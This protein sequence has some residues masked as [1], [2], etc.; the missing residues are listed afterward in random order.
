MSDVSGSRSKPT[1]RSSIR[2]SLNF[3]SVGKAFAD[4]MNKER[5]DSA[6]KTGKD[7]NKPGG[8]KPRA[9]LD[10]KPSPPPS[11]RPRTP[12]SK[13]I[14]ARRR[15][16]LAAASLS[17]R[18][19]AEEPSVAPSKTTPTPQSSVPA[20]SSA[21]R[22]RPGSSSNLPKYRPK[23]IVVENGKKPSSPSLS[24]SRKRTSTSDD[25]D[26]TSSGDMAV[27]A[28][29]Q[30][31]KSRPIS[32]LPQ[33]A[34]TKTKTSGA[35]SKSN[36]P[37]PETSPSARK[38]SP[39]RM[40]KAV[41][42]A[43]TIPRPSS[44]SSSSSSFSPRTP[45]ASPAKGA[46]GAHSVKVQKNNVSDSS[47][48]SVHSA[49][50]ES[51]LVRHV[52][53]R[54][55]AETPPALHPGNMSHITEADSDDEE[56]DVEIMLAPIAAPGAPTPAMPR[57]QTMRNRSRLVPATPS[58]PLLPIHFEPPE[59]SS[60][61][62]KNQNSPSFLRPNPSPASDRSLRGGS[63]LSWEQLASEASRTIPVDELGT[64][65]SDMSAPFQPGPLSPMPTGNGN[66]SM[67]LDVNFQNL[68]SSPGLSAFNSPSGYGSISQVL[69]PNATPSPAFPRHSHSHS[70][71]QHKESDGPAVDTAIATLL[72][73]QLSSAENTAKERLM[74][75]QELEEEIHNLKQT[76]THETEV[77]SQQVSILESQLKTSLEARERSE[78][79]QFAYT[80]SLEEQLRYTE[81]QQRQAVREAVE[82][83]RQHAETSLRSTVE[84]QNRKLN[85]ACAASLAAREWRNVQEQCESELDVLAADRDTLALLFGELD[86]A[87]QQLL[88]A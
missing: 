52:R 42:A 10:T 3:A 16:S 79:E 31:R 26:K 34:A 87:R 4:V 23:S 8:L 71:R 59:A 57:L 84:S 47:E 2:Q 1:T 27:D 63:I 20:R 37:Q 74:R 51:P 70:Q 38:A 64:M 69:L 40:V 88:I 45:K 50:P 54:S 39:N 77:L 67:L 82:S 75:L 48:G 36:T 86:L 61:P 85:A 66:G 24:G 15:S 80:A 73:L 33:R 68:P 60:T 76:R 5:N 29:S 44:A 58:K 28:S 7:V 32:P 13:T 12:D 53:Q 30:R 9:S 35:N 22:P 11:K 6:K 41:K 56:D 49:L 72:R 18:N 19:S 55:K 65:L 62:P 81:V 25:E 43:S 78:G 21:L 83:A 17:T 14:T 46:R